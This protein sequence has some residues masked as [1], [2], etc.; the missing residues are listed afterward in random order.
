MH[1]HSLKLINFKNYRDT[2]LFFSPKINCLVG[3]NGAGK[4]NLLEAVYYLSFTRSFSN[5]VDYQNIRHGEDFFAIHGEYFRDGEQHYQVSCIQKKGQAKEFSLNQKRYDRLA[6]HIGLIPLVIVSPYDRDL[7]NDGSEVRRKYIDGVISQFDHVYLDDLLT[8]NRALASRNALL[9]QFAETGTFDAFMLDIYTP[10]LVS[11]GQRI[12]EKRK[13]F[14][15]AF[16]PVFNHFYREISGHREE[17]SIIYQSQLN[18]SEMLRLLEEALPRDRALRYT[19]VGI[20]KD[21]LEFLIN[22]FPV[23]KF[24]SQGQQKSFVVAIKLAQFEFTRSI[25]GYKPILLLDD[26][27]DKLDEERVKTLIRLAGEEQFGQVFI[28]DTHLSR[29]ES[30]FTDISIDHAIFGVQREMTEGIALVERFYA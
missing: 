4:T 19:T 5:P 9:R 1:L 27:F 24:G 13:A 25:I 17:V 15:Q 22:G 2:S 8:Y 20:H 11:I 14:L 30:I 29:I 28:T 3:S 21:D 6:D 16:L 26:I 12:F 7:I 18:D 23:K 10:Q